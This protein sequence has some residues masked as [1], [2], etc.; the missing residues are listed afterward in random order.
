M[1]IVLSLLL[2]NF[3]AITHVVCIFMICTLLRRKPLG[4]QT[5]VDLVLVHT[6]VVQALNII[7]H[8][9]LCHWAL[10]AIDPVNE[11]LAICFTFLADC[12]TLVQCFFYLFNVIIKVVEKFLSI[13]VVS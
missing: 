9:V 13:Y 10:L 3:V 6:L 1:N 5:L 12:L 11:Y 4:M 7:V 8:I 2:L